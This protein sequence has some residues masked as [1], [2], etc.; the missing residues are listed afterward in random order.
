MSQRDYRNPGRTSYQPLYDLNLSS[1]W[2]HRGRYW[3]PLIE[4][5]ILEGLKEPVEEGEKK[6]PKFQV[7]ALCVFVTVLALL[8]FGAYMQVNAITQALREVAGISVQQAI[9][10]LND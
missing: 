4:T 2:W 8:S 7:K 5:E 10:P 3:S 6:K 1:F 9:E